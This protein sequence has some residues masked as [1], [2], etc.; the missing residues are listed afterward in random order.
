[1]H[2][3][4]LLEEFNFQNDLFEI[5]QE[6]PLQNMTFVLFGATGDL[7]QRKLFPALYNLYLDGKLPETISVVSTGRDYCSDETFQYKVEKALYAY[8]RRSIHAS[9]LPAFLEKFNQIILNV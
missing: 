3:E 5:K 7:A 9:S 4:N 6:R 8:S 1:M 2:T